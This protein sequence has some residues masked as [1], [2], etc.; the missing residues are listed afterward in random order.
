[1]T[2][3]IRLVDFTGLSIIIMELNNVSVG[4]EIALFEIGMA[5]LHMQCSF[6]N[7]QSML[8]VL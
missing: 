3:S 7:F 4:E 8:R 2:I 6:V 1:M 5:L